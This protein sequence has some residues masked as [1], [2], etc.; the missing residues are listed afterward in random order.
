MKIARTGEGA[1]PPL[2]K[3]VLAPL[4]DHE[5]PLGCGWLGAE[6]DEAQRRERQG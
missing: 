5:A 4:R 3:D 6:A 1:H 2:L